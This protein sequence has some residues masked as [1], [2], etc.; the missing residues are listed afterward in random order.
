MDTFHINSNNDNCICVQCFI[1]V[2][3]TSGM[4]ILIIVICCLYGTLNIAFGAVAFSASVGRQEEYLACKNSVTSCWCGYLSEARCK[5]FAYGPAAI[6]DPIIPCF[7][8]IQ[9]GLTFLVPAYPGCPRKEA[10]KLVFCIAPERPRIQR[11][12][13]SISSKLH[14]FPLAKLCKAGLKHGDF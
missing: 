8:K 3:W 11:P 4:A 2:G 10:V 14:R 6:T 13:K 7:I 9:I 12:I 5:W 1:A